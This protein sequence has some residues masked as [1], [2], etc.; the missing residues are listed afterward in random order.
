MGDGGKKQVSYLKETGA[1]TF[2]L[3]VCFFVV[4]FVLF[5]FCVCVV[6]FFF[7]FFILK[8]NEI[9]VAPLIQTT[10]ANERTRTLAK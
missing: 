8:K 9:V 7:V 5:L 3:W 4:V 6:V 10:T 2:S 1:E